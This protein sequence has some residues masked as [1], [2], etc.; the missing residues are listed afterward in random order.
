LVSR[1]TIKRFLAYGAVLCLAGAVGA[2]AQ[3]NSDVPVYDNTGASQQQTPSGKPA[4]TIPSRQGGDD[5]TLEISPQT[6]IVPPSGASADIPSNRE[7]R[8]GQD[9]TSVDR[10]F[11]PGAEDL[12]KNGGGGHA[13][14]SQSCLGINVRYRDYCFKG[15]EEHGLEVASIDRNSPAEAAG[16]KQAS[17]TSALSVAEMIDVIPLA[18]A[19][20]NK[21]IEDQ[22]ESMGGDLIIA[23][24][25]E[26]IRSRADLDDAISRAHPGDTL[27]LTVL[28]PL[29]HHDHQE[30]KVAVTVG[31]WQ[32]GNVDTCA[33]MTTASSARPG[34]P[35]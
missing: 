25:D 9:E 16:L 19:L 22:K 21:K 20:I 23:V 34:A 1:S 4:A 14:S 15:A 11:K 29:P 3:N 17:N 33:A 26:R 30:L 5:A 2:S 8:P 7:F 10:N 12:G 27:Y 6:G 24:D 31:K 18:N 28:R 32:P 13:G 35:E